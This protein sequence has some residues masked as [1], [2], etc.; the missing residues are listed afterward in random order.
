VV[1]VFEAIRYLVLTVYFVLLFLLALNGA[2]R[3]YLLALLFRRRAMRVRPPERDADLP[4]VTVQIPIF[5]EASVAPRLLDAVA[6]LDY[7]PERLEIQV[8]DDSTD[9][10]PIQIG[11]RVEELR[12]RGLDVHHLRRR[13]RSG[14]KAGA[15][16][17]GLRAARG[18]LLAIFDADFVPSPGF[19]RGMVPHFRDPRIGMVQARWGHLNRDYSILTRVQ[20][21]LLDG[22][23]LVEHAARHLSGRFFNFNGTAGIWRRECVVEAGGWQHDTL[24]E[25]LDLSYRAQ[26]AGWRFV[27]APSA[28]APGELPIDLASFKSQQRR[29]AKGSI[30]TAR[31]ILPR[32]IAAPLPL[33]VRI[34]ALCHLTAN[35]VYPCLLIFSVLLVPSMLMRASIPTW[36]ALAIDLPALALSTLAFW[37]FYAVADRR[38]GGSAARA[39][40][41][42]PMLMALGIGLAVNNARAV[43][44]G[45]F[46]PVGSF[47]RT[48][49]HRV[50]DG[51]GRPPDR[52]YRIARPPRPWA[53]AALFVYFTAGLAAAIALG[54]WPFI[55]FLALF[56]SG[57]GWMSLGGWA[58]SIRARRL[59]CLDP[60]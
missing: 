32:L 53:E 23:F 39:I 9:D 10:T 37:L 50:E 57:N 16:D 12:H 25:D 15:L 14:F 26:L 58:E 11:R 48:P 27:F 29:W 44:E 43:F 49:K 40:R 46:G 54:Q 51:S 8:L 36:L 18:E 28:V 13:E 5:N 2:H 55:P 35:L 20:A 4:L 24:T 56:A 45:S 7:P 41:T 33:P 6:S 47:D 19:L 38:A 59:S 34:E 42:M 22:H 31:K 52:R 17:A 3:L 30:Q 21:L 60:G 1:S